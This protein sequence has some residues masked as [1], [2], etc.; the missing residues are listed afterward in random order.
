[1]P[2]GYVEYEIDG[3]V[4]GVY[5]VQAMGLDKMEEEDRNRLIK[6]VAAYQRAVGEED[7]APP[8]K[9]SQ[10]AVQGKISTAELLGED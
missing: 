2:R 5:P 4:Y 6:K 3:V 10:K 7:N 1:M 8:A 9:P